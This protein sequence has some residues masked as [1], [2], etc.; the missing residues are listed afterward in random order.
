VAG[1]DHVCHVLVALGR[2]LHDQLRAARDGRRKGGGRM[3]GGKGGGAG[4]RGVGP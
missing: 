3:D 2:L 1:V 4:E